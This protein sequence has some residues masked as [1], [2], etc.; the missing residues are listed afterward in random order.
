MILS[1]VYVL[2]SRWPCKTL[3]IFKRT[4]T[5]PPIKSQLWT[6]NSSAVS[7]HAKWRAV[8]AYFPNLLLMKGSR[9]DAVFSLTHSNGCII[10]SVPIPLSLGRRF[11]FFGE[12]DS[13]YSKLKHSNSMIN[14]AFF[15]HFQQ[16]TGSLRPK[17]R[18]IY[19]F[20]WTGCWSW[21]VDQE[22]SLW[23]WKWGRM[24]IFRWL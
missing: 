17:D 8:P 12:A 4:R 18:K 24:W 3:T 16:R 15:V 6:I 13:I 1:V 20:G 11:S 2:L 19:I 21:R 22:L 7:S 10:M 23:V 5:S 14:F 9:I